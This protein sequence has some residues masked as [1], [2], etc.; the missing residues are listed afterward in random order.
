MYS[1][2]DPKANKDNPFTPSPDLPLREQFLYR[3]SALEEAVRSG[4]R[5]LDERMDRFQTEIHDRHIEVNTRI[6]HLEV[7][8]REQF[9][10]KRQRVDG[11]E[12]RVA[13]LETW[14]KVVTARFA[15]LLAVVTVAWTVLA[16][17]LRNIIGV[18]NG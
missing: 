4:F 14:S 7:D 8:T 13:E 15:V 2:D 9:A 16:P 17:F 1:P 18:S 10:F 5:R 3:F 12:K 6:T 11:L